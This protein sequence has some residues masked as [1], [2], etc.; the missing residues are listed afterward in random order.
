MVRQLSGS[1]QQLMGSLQAVVGSC[2]LAVRQLSGRCQAGVRQLSGSCQAV[3]LKL[4]GS[5]QAI[6]RQL[7]GSCHTYQVDGS[8]QAIIKLAWYVKIFLHFLPLRIKSCFSV[9]NYIISCKYN[10]R[11]LFGPVQ[12]KVH[13]LFIRSNNQFGQPCFFFSFQIEITTKTLAVKGPILYLLFCHCYGNRGCR[14]FKWGV[15]N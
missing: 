12:L 7:S 9:V 1:C 15:Q 4:S 6:V 10:L 13:L 11:I 5:C 14:V 8:H 2:Q 3:V